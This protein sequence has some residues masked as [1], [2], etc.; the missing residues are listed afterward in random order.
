MNFTTIARVAGESNEVQIV[1]PS[2]KALVAIT[3]DPE[4]TGVPK[5]LKAGRYALKLRDVQPL[6][7]QV[8]AQ[9]EYERGSTSIY[10]YFE[11]M[12]GRKDEVLFDQLTIQID[13]PGVDVIKEHEWRAGLG[14]R[15]NMAVVGSLI[16]DM[17]AEER[18][19]ARRVTARVAGE[20]RS[21][22][23]NGLRAHLERDDSPDDTAGYKQYVRQTLDFVNIGK[24]KFT[25]I[26]SD[27][28]Q[29][30]LKWASFYANA[31]NG[32]KFRFS[33]NFKAGKPTTYECALSYHGKEAASRKPADGSIKI[34]DVENQFI[35]L[36][37]KMQEKIATLMDA[38]ARCVIGKYTLL[39]NSR[40]SGHAYVWYESR[41]FDSEGNPMVQF[42]VNIDE[43]SC[44]SLAIGGSEAK[45]DNGG[46]RNL[47]ND[48]SPKAVRT[49]LSSKYDS[50]ED[51]IKAINT[52]A[53]IISLINNATTEV[54][55]TRRVIQLN[56]VNETPVF[57]DDDPANLFDSDN[58]FY[59][60]FDTQAQRD[61]AL[62]ALRKAITD[63]GG[64]IIGDKYWKPTP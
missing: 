40:N 59:V 54:G 38:P 9:Y 4:L 22:D 61:S 45:S 20:S 24:I 36:K 8:R 16:D 7:Y 25:V 52:S 53:W 43:R 35:A 17:F 21:I 56:V 50:F 10:V 14:L 46:S 3:K 6:Q 5:T 19:K 64:K 28:S 51:L 47:T 60:S 27:Y 15:V 41:E 12:H 48:A 2:W 62:T 29:G 23:V 58:D 33:I 63:N 44:T 32:I 49:I 31:S 55:S 26:D 34:S 18:K 30:Y 11:Y 39:R 1:P 57:N 37:P 42:T 13:A